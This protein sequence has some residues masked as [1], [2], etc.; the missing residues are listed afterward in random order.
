MLFYF[1]SS[2]FF[3]SFFFLLFIAFLL[4]ANEFEAFQRFGVRLRIALLS[5]CSA[6]FFLI[7]IPVLL[8]WIGIVPFVLSIAT[9]FLFCHFW[10]HQLKK[11]NLNFLTIRK[12]LIYPSCFIHFLFIT[13]YFFKILP[14]VPL[15]ITYMGVYHGVEKKEG[16]YY[17]T[18]YRPWW[19]FWHHGDQWF[20][21][22][23][24]DTLYGFASIFSPAK[25][26]DTVKVR[27]LLHSDKHGWQTQDNIPLEIVG[28]RDMGF[29]GYTA[30]RSFSPGHW[31]FQVE[32]SDE[33]E[34]GRLYFKVFEENADA[35]RESKEDIF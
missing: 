16:A 6:S 13:L 34:I 7:L 29:R 17:L 28:G 20:Y 5:L 27:W 12:E 21:A 19:R 33:R 4:V 15:S 23:P 1:K 14:P 31:R 30:K 8:G 11:K 10:F 26:K 2:S 32:T 25:F 18:H 9:S 35:P 24:G 3:A 22:K